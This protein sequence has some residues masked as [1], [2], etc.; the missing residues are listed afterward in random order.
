[1]NYLD[2]LSSRSSFDFE[3]FAE[4]NRQYGSSLGEASLR[5]KMQEH[6]KNNEIVRVGRG[7]YA[8]SSG[9]TAGYD[10]AYSELS[11]S[12]AETL[13]EKHPHLDFTIFELVQLKWLV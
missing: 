3:G 8:V 1:M 11:C 5:K 4:A 10:Y 7:L 2:V 9:N 12:I 6:L 13:K